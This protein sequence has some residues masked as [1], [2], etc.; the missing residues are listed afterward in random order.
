MYFVEREFNQYHHINL[1]IAGLHL[2]FSGNSR[3]YSNISGKDIYLGW[4]IVILYDPVFYY[5][6]WFSPFCFLFRLITMLNI[7]KY[8]FIDDLW[9]STSLKFIAK[10][11]CNI[12]IPRCL[13]AR[14]NFIIVLKIALSDIT[15]KLIINDYYR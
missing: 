7:K 14:L 3:V 13:A 11:Y 8:S 6:V 9:N 2:R 12:L 15:S 1:Y 10:N 5:T 4:T